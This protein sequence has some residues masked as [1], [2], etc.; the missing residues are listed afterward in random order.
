MKKLSLLLAMLMVLAVFAMGCNNTPSNTPS[1]TDP[2]PSTP[3]TTDPTPSTPGT[4]DP[5]PSGKRDDV[6]IYCEMVWNGL[7][8]HDSTYYVDQQVYNQI[9]DRLTQI[10]DDGVHEPMLA[11]EW[12][13]SE[14]GLTYTFKLRDDVKFQNGEPFTADDVVFTFER[15]MQNP[16]M[17]ANVNMIDSVTE[18]D[19]HTV[20]FKVKN[21]SPMFALYTQNIYVMN[22]EWTEA[23]GD[24]IED[25]CG[26]GAYKLVSYDINTEAKFEAF[27]ESWHGAPSIKNATIRVITDATTAVISLEAG[28]IDYLFCY[29][30]SAFA[31]LEASGNF[32]TLKTTTN[33]TAYIHINCEKKPFDDVNVRKA[34]SYATDRETM[35]DIAYEGNAVPAYF[36]ANET[37]FGIEYAYMEQYL[38]DLDKA[39]EHLATAGY[40]DGLDLGTMDCI[41]GSYHVKI[42][43]V[44]QESLSQINCKLELRN[45]ETTSSDGPSGNFTMMSGGGGFMTDA[46]YLD[47]RYCTSYIGSGNTSRYSNERV[48]ELFKLAESETDQ[49]KRLEYYHEMTQLVTEDAPNIPVFH[50]QQM[51]VWNKDLNANPHVDSAFCT[52]IREMSW[53]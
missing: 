7:D 44:L 16:K 29:N 15:A 47:R 11:T 10:S 5:A 24:K 43:Q 53:K 48:D 18:I 36:L 19:E 25:A 20:E 49:S 22:R 3:G 4:T 45:S 17:A 30:P 8:P 14:D 38:F 1:T 50:K 27:D 35:I 46:A 13:V 51:W 6:V 12:A 31:P 32:N 28:E 42:A 21:R 39:K 9:Y 40:P 33:H 37:V 52:M 23:Q 41:T 2:T 34:L 26:T